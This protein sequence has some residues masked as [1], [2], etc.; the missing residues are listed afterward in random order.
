MRISDWSSDVCSSDLMSIEQHAEWIAD[1]IQHLS[2][3]SI[4]VIEPSE[5]A[6]KSWTQYVN[7]W[8]DLTLFPKAKSW[9]TGAN[10][11]DKPQGFMPFIGGLGNYTK[12]CNEEIGRASCRER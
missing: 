9:Y 4:E 2:A 12:I 3:H 5:A 11:T 6:E 8:A 10:I 1:C 7:D